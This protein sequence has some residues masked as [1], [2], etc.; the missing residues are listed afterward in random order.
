[1]AQTDQAWDWSVE[2]RD[3]EPSELELLRGTV[4]ELRAQLDQAHDSLRMHRRREQ[5]LNQALR[6][7]DGAKPWQR[8]RLRTAL[9]NR[10]LL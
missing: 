5:D 4:A 1:M 10:R 2:L 6:Q 8:R 9:R 7:L 3:G